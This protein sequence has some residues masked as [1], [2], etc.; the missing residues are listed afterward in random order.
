LEPIFNK[1]NKAQQNSLLKMKTFVLFEKSGGFGQYITTPQNTVKY[2]YDIE[3]VYKLENQDEK[4]EMYKTQ[5]AEGIAR[6][7]LAQNANQTDIDNFVSGIKDKFK[8]YLN[9]LQ[10]N[11]QT[12]LRNHFMQTVE[13]EY[14]QGFKLGE[15]FR[16]VLPR[17]TYRV[18]QER[19]DNTG[20]DGFFEINNH[21][22]Q[23]AP[24]SL[25][26]MQK[27][28]LEKLILSTTD[29]NRAI[30]LDN[31]FD[32]KQEY[33]VLQ[34]SHKLWVNEAGKKNHINIKLIGHHV[35]HPKIDKI[36]GDKN[37]TGDTIDIDDE[38]LKRNLIIIQK[39]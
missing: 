25:A 4:W 7:V 12:S 21:Q 3:Q 30:F 28:G 18:L 33:N 11:C 1:L 36:M 9:S 39:P 22:F 27:G 37:Q 5:L 8:A 29:E 19:L 2:V 32:C 15:K 24:A 20:E 17:I 6:S 16:T 31:A 35:Q 34:L 38:F 26:L 23:I 14:N 13:T 10:L